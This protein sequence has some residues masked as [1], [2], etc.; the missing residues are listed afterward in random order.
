MLFMVHR[1]RVHGVTQY[2]IVHAEA[3]GT[4]PGTYYRRTIGEWDDAMRDAERMA[5]Q[6]ARKSSGG[7]KGDYYCHQIDWGFEVRKID[8]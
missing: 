8:L 2:K 7:K 3:Q 5:I 1:R 6:T 4:A